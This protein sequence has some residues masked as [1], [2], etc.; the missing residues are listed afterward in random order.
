MPSYQ[1]L[2]L[3]DIPFF[4]LRGQPAQT[5]PAFAQQVRGPF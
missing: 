3:L 1:A 5:V 2:R 4:L